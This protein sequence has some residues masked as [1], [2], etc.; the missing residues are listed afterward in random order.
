[1]SAYKELMMSELKILEETIHP[2]ITKV[3]ELFEDKNNYYIVA[4][5]SCGGCLQDKMDD[6][7]G[8]SN[9]HIVKILKMILLPLNYMHHTKKITHRDIKMEN[10]LCMP[11]GPKRTDFVVKLTDFGFA[12][13]FKPGEMMDLA[14][15]SPMYMAPE[16]MAM[17]DYDCRVD[18]WAVGVLTYIMV[19][20]QPPF[21]DN[22]EKK[23]ERKIKWDEPLYTKKVFTASV[24]A[25]CI[26]FIK[27]CLT[28]KAADRPFIKDLLEHPW[29]KSDKQ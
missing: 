14:L 26:D 27:K 5:L 4:E 20:G 12:A 16:L 28:K 15:G 13:Y 19:T 6:L 17:K 23:L 2:N 24:P 9:P 22:D 11:N 29:I 10:I 18:V 21:Y 25:E 1:M 3:F 7:G 8:F